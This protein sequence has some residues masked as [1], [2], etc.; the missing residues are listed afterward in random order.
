MTRSKLNIETVA[1]VIKNQAGTTHARTVLTFTLKNQTKLDNFNME[2]FRIWLLDEDGV[3]RAPFVEPQ[4]NV[5]ADAWCDYD[6]NPMM[7]SVGPSQEQL[8]RVCFL[9]RP[10]HHTTAVLFE[11]QDLGIHEA[12]VPT[13]VEENP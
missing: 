9:F 6:F 1:A 10:G 8:I 2:D 7:V 3:A 11:S 13:V 5:P 12:V 4:T